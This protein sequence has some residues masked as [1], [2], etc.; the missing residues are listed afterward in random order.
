MLYLSM[1]IKQRKWL[2]VYLE[3]GNATKAAL[4]AYQCK[5]RRVAAQI[6]YENMRKPDVLAVMEQTFEAGDLTPVYFAKTLKR[7]ID[8]GLAGEAT[9]A[10]ALRGMEIYAKITGLY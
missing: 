9:C 4:Y 6:G 2:K 8:S 10:D 7:V 5:N 1:T 3:T